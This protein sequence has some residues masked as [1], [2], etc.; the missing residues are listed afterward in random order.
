MENKFNL[1]RGHTTHLPHLPRDGAQLIAIA[2]LVAAIAFLTVQLIAMGGLL[3]QAQSA[4]A[5]AAAS[6]T[7]QQETLKDAWLERGTGMALVAYSVEW[8]EAL[9]DAKAERGISVGNEAF[10]K[11]EA[12]KDA[13]LERGAGMTG[14]AYSLTRQET[15]K[16]M[17]LERSA[18]FN[19]A[20]I[21]E[22]EALKDAWLERGSR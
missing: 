3:G 21:I 18:K 20:A 10:I 15:L 19:A 14:I 17:W 1:K 11:Q 16:D 5:L 7:Q 22:Q 6:A 2:F 13:W 9:K 12:A 4:E 8:Q